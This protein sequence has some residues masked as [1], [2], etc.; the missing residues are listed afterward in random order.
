MNIINKTEEQLN[1]A[2][3][4]SPDYLYGYFIEIILFIIIKM[5]KIKHFV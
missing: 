4:H 2:K 3:F 1:L 5:S